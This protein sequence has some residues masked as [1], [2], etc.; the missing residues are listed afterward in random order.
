MFF[1]LCNQSSYHTKT[2]QWLEKQLCS[3]ATAE[4]LL[5]VTAVALTIIGAILINGHSYFGLANVEL[6]IRAKNLF[7]TAACCF[8]IMGIFETAVTGAHMY[9]VNK[10]RR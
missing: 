4:S 5:L 1:G 7:I 3:V 8:L 9:E 6:A 2:T 10:A